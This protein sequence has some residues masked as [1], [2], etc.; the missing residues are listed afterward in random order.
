MTLRALML[1][2]VAAFATAGAQQRFTTQVMIVP[3]FRSPEKGWGGKAADIVRS[4]VSGGFPRSELRVIS[5]G[6]VDDWLRR[7]GFEQNAE[8]SEGELKELAK[9]FRADER[10]TASVVRAGNQVQ[11]DALLTPVR[12]LRLSQPVTATAP[13]VDAAAE[14]VTKELIAARRQLIPLRQCE[15]AVRSGNA[16]EAVTF[17]AAGIGAYARAVPARLCLLNAL[18]HLQ[19]PPDSI[20]NVAQAVLAVAPA[21][22]IALGDLAMALDNQGK[23]ALAAPIW[24]RLLAT[25]S[26]SEELIDRVVN[27]LSAEGNAAMAQPI[28]DR[29]TAE[30]EDNL[31]LLQL[32]WRVHLA[33][34]DW[35]GAVEAG[36]KLLARD[37]AAQADPVFYARLANA[38]QEDSEPSQ[39]V[40]IA[41]AGVTKFPKDA[42][43]Y[44]VYV[45]LLRAENEVALGRGL[46]AFPDNPELHALAAQNLKKAGN[47]KDALKET[48]RALAANPKL[49]HGDL[50]VAQLEF[51]LGELDSAFAAIEL[52][53][54]HGEERQQAGGLALKFGDA[55]YKAAAASQKRDDFQ[56]A[57][58]F[59]NLALTLAPS[60]E[61][62]FLLGV[63]ALSISQLATTEAVSAKS[64]DLFKLA[65]S[66]LT[67]AEINLVS[68]GSVS[69][70]DAKQLL[71][72]VAKLRPYVS[73]QLKTLCG[74]KPSGLR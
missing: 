51:E 63:S 48:K 74:N 11:I 24:V 40:A 57:I 62:K 64:C 20:V 61:A 56:R 33:T 38:Y 35:K 54:K 70:N 8:L 47:A 32:R 16:N 4:R 59:L 18:S 1:L 65:D 55:L 45:Q 66:S 58:R 36:E 34:G 14:A 21:S 53:P 49:V 72:N 71:D 43:L 9:K 23:K 31:I 50:Q 25:D 28:I 73:E 12:D 2:I 60:A 30:H 37:L 22:S 5:G 39:A 29:G 26:S 6:D 27:A 46:A 69:P 52:A 44:L 19:V 7:S 13:N 17:A 41:G 67:D 15:N 42:A 10:V 68:G 3:A